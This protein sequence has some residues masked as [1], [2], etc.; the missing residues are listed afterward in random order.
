[1]AV[2]LGLS[3]SLRGAR[4]GKG[5]AELCDVLKKIGNKRELFEYLDRE[6]SSLLGDYLVA[7]ESGTPHSDLLDMLLTKKSGQKGLSNSEAALAAG[8]WGAAQEGF[9]IR[10]CNLSHYFP[11]SGNTRNLAAL[12]DIVLE[13]DGFLLAGPVYFGDRSS[14]AQEFIEFLSRDSDCL[15]H[16]KNKVYGGISAGAK[17]N[18]GQET[19]LVYQLID[20]IN[21][22]M[23]GVGNDSASTSQYG[24]TV[25]AGDVGSIVSDEYGLNTCIDTGRRVAKMSKLMSLNTRYVAKKDQPV[26]IEIWL[27]QDNDSSY[28]LKQID[29]FLS[30]LDAVENVRISLRNFTGSSTHRCIACDICPISQGTTEKYRCIITKKSDL[31]VADHDNLIRA[32]A[33]LLAAFSPVEK[34]NVISVYQKFIER[35]RYLRRDHYAIGDNLVAPFVISE[36]NSNQNLHIRMATSLIRHH[37]VIHHPIL[38][39]KNGNEILNWNVAKGQM[40]SFVENAKAI[41]YARRYQASNDGEEER[42]YNPIGY[43]I[44]AEHAKQFEEDGIDNNRGA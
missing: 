10:Y 42:K 32:D 5:L 44:S 6:T 23:L 7:K 4:H 26:N 35:T 25:V 43:V 20:M 8:L 3:A 27:V 40:R 30:E 22:N 12:K 9:E 33:I 29:K 14:L 17:R 38:L 36:V 16:I 2:I 21:M 18:G 11:E 39:F 13:S 37:S 34:A 24:G 31:F 41:T 19:S 1:M 28:G 15:E